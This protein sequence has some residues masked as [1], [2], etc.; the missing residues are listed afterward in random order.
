LGR[1]ALIAIVLV[2]SGFIVAM[3]TG[4]PHHFISALEQYH[5]LVP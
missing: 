3:I 4:D 5:N 2:I 1:L